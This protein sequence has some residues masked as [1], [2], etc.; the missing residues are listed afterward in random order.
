MTP[1]FHSQ[2]RQQQLRDEAQKWMDTPIVPRS[3][4]PGRLGGTD[5]VLLVAAI[6]SACGYISPPDLHSL[7]VYE[8]DW[9]SHTKHPVLE[10]YLQQHGYLDN[11]L[12]LDTP[13]QDAMPGDVLVFR[14]GRGI[15]FHLGLVIEYGSFIH[16]LRPCVGFCGCDHPR[17]SNIY[18]Y[19]LRPLEKEAH[20]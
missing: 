6:L 9:H 17:M 1:Y 18:Q 12:R 16:A 13:I 2:Q 7:P 15:I 19:L 8:L 10:D 20:L 3:M 11:A 4:A 5:C 14:P